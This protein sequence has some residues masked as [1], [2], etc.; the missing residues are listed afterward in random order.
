VFAST[1]TGERG[2]WEP[3]PIAVEG[4]NST[5][6][7]GPSRLPWSTTVSFGPVCRHLVDLAVTDSSLGII[8]PGD[9]GWHRGAHYVDQLDR[10]ARHEYVPFYLSWDLIERAKDSETTLEPAP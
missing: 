7:V 4:D 5:P 8:P 9:S 2:A 10:W 3:A 6:C 1:L